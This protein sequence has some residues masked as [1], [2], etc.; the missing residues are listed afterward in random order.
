MNSIPE[1]LSVTRVA[2][3]LGLSTK[4]VYKLVESGRLESLRPTPRTI[5]IT[6][7]SL[8]AFVQQKIAQQRAEL[9]LDLP[10][11]LPGRKRQV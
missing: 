4:R 8:E 9:C 3:A 6:R 1:L 7:S 10:P 5:R 2:K 11:I